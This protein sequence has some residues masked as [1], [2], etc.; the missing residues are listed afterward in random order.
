MPILHWLKDEE[1][2]KTSSRVPDRL[3]K[4][5]DKLSYGSQA[6]WTRQRRLQANWGEGQMRMETNK[7]TQVAV[8]LLDILGEVVLVLTAP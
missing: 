5:D 7:G 3:H 4:V 1:A 6:R 8:K 2:R